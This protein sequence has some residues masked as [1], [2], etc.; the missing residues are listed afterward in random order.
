[1]IYAENCLF[2][3]SGS[4][5]VSLQYGGNYE[6]NYCTMASYESGGSAIAATN[7]RCI[8]PTC[9]EGYLFNPIDLKINNCLLVGDGEDEVIFVDRSE[10]QDD[11]TYQLNHCI[12]RVKEL[13]DTPDFANFFDNCNG[14]DNIDGTDTIFLNPIEFDFSLDTMSLAIEK[15]IPINGIERDIINNLRDIGSPDVGCFEF[16]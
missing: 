8:E 9:L 11:F 13:L 10:A 15:A 3:N 5:T 2:Y 6:L 1:M 14:C 16:Q 4:S 7:F 12:V